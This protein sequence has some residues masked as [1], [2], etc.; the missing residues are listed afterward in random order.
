MLRSVIWQPYILFYIILQHFTC[1]AISQ[2]G[3]HNGM[4][5]RL[6]ALWVKSAY[7]LT[8][9]IMVSIFSCFLL[10]K[11]IAFFSDFS[12]LK[13]VS[14]CRIDQS[15]CMIYYYNCSVQNQVC[16][17][18]WY[19]NWIINLAWNII[20]ALIYFLSVLMRLCIDYHVCLECSICILCL[21][22]LFL[23]GYFA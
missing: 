12:P 7:I 9:K 11:T 20:Y 4:A 23:P 8:V 21:G 17:L 5:Y 6:N 10:L 22:S 1:S 13:V 15:Y 16:C 14:K 19:L 2:P 3:A 18:S